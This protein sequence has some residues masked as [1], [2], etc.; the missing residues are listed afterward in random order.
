MDRTNQAIEEYYDVIVVGA[1]SAGIGVS[2]LLQRLGI[3][4]TILEKTTIGA[5]FKQ[6]PKETQFISP[7]FTGNFFRMPDLNSISPSTS[8]AFDLLTE[9]PTGEEYAQYLEQVSKFFKLSIA[10]D[11]EVKEVEDKNGGFLLHTSKGIY[12]SSFVI[13]AA[14]EYQ[15]PKANSFE[16][17]QLCTHYAE[18]DSFAHVLG[19]KS[20]VIGAYESGF[21]AAINLA[22]LGKKV[23]LIDS[24]NYLELI[25]SDSSYSLSPFTRDR[26]KSVLDDIEYYE[27][28]SVQK[29][30]FVNA[31]YLIITDTGETFVSDDEPINCTGFDTSLK[32]VE[33]LFEFE[34]DYPLLTEFDESRKTKNLFL[35][36]PQVKHGTAL[37]CFIYKYRQRFAIV[38]EEIAKRTE[39][40]LDRIGDIIGE[41]QYNNFYLKDLSCCD[42]ECVC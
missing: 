24:A 28:T 5:S 9:H 14:G 34:E 6:W 7:S 1:G 22:Q 38:A 33:E 3:S 18:V 41:Y 32:L 29:V 15:Y 31:K 19:K 4:Y 39:V 27:E 10:T 30:K 13:W 36:G 8:P 21:D 42:D 16:G 25:N 11:V 23:T 2:I 26:M 37:F 35:V 20:V 40:P 12:A 17:E